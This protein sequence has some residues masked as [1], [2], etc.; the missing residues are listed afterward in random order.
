MDRKTV[1]LVSRKHP[2]FHWSWWRTRG[3]WWQ[4]EFSPGRE[5][6]L[7]I[8]QGD[9]KPF[10]VGEAEPSSS[11]SASRTPMLPTGT[12]V[13]PYPLTNQ[14]KKTSVLVSRQRHE[15]HLV[16]IQVVVGVR[17]SNCIV[18]REQLESFKR[19]QIT[20]ILW[21]LHQPFWQQWQKKY[22]P[23]AIPILTWQW[24]F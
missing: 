12:S 15:N 1:W 21:L 2:P 16:Q 11:L 19:H 13:S 7:Y 14:K 9:L 10:G 22:Q 17:T 6:K 20:H 23:S 8:V 18:T 5:S 24:Q 4:W 3:A